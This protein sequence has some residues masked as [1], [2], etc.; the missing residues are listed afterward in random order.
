MKK[1]KSEQINYQE[2]DYISNKN[3]PT[4]KSLRPDRFTGELHQTLKKE[5]TPIFLKLFQKIE[6]DGILPNSFYEASL[7]L[8]PK[9]DK[10]TIRKKITCQYP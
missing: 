5:L 3:L 6:E 9:P 1:R 4:D 10:D 2:R 8:I 7:I